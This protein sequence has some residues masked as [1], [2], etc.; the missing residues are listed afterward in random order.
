MTGTGID[1]KKERIVK[2]SYMLKV[3]KNKELIRKLEKE[4]RQIEARIREIS[5]AKKHNKSIE[6]KISYMYKKV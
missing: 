6:D 3:I 5:R 1:Y 2:I 4:K